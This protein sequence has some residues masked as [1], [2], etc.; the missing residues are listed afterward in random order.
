MNGAIVLLALVLRVA[1]LDLKPVHFD[2]GVNGWFIDQ[3]T[4]Q[5]YY[6]YDPGNFHG[7]LHFY[8]LF[9]PL[10]L[11][12]RSVWA[13]RLPIAL[14]STLCVAMML[15]YRRYLPD[16][17]CRFAALAMAISPGCVFY[18]RT[19]IHE[20][21]LLLFLLLAVWGLAGL[22]RDGERRQ[23]WA[24]GLGLTGMVLTKETYAIHWI[25]L[26]LAAP[27]LLIFERVS[28]SEPFAFGGR[29]WTN[30]DFDRVVVVCT[31]LIFFFYTGALLDWSSLPGLWQTFAKWTQTGTGGASGHEKAWSYFIELICRYEWPALLGMGATIG[32][33]TRGTNRLARYLA[34]YGFGALTAYSLIA[35]KT[36]WCVMVLLWPFYFAFG[37][38]THRLMEAL[39]RWTIGTLT[40]VV[41]A[42]SLGASCL[43]NFRDF[44]NEDEPYVYVQ[45][46]PDID[47][48]LIPLRR[49]VAL[50]PM[51]Y[52]VAGHVLTTDHH[53]LL[54]LLG[55]FTHVEMLD[56]NGEPATWDGAFLLVD[57]S[58]QERVERQL[59]GAYFKD[60]L[61]LRGNANDSEVLYLNAASFAFCFPG[62]TPEFVPSALD[63]IE[64]KPAALP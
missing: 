20:S 47:K 57:E 48:L 5:G 2:E 63:P 15:A 51:N 12:G 13:L 11:F 28:A 61:R 36:P 19:A 44:T 17:A 18:G 26:A 6:H 45:T 10:R 14:I 32:L 53:P 24:A 52:H 60:A 9:G 39:D 38:A 55:D 62:R 25:A 43:L 27:V 4:R 16:R 40:A 8:A 21:W 7:P 3:M 30:F 64:L 34:I 37:L 1:A 41:C 42:Y 59:T 23:L 50:D 46:L 56:P 54:W 33:A 22:W 49:L 35:Y 58:E 29:R 31:L